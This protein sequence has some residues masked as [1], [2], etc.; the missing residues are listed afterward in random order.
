[1]TFEENL[2]ILEK[3]SEKIRSEGTSLD[4][5]IEC[6]KE[7]IKAY[8]ECSKILSEAKQKITVFGKE[9]DIQR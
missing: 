5:A 9:S 2:K 3:Y 8:D 6:Y 1:M 4:D 7:G